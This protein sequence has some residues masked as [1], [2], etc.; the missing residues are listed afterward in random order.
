M[1]KTNAR[2]V[3]PF[4]MCRCLDPFTPELGA[5][6]IVP[7]AMHFA[8]SLRL[9]RACLGDLSRVHI[10]VDRECCTC[11]YSPAIAFMSPDLCIKTIC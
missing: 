1:F 9:S 6:R 3:V 4:V 10:Q 5:T 2:S 8:V 7:G 11:T